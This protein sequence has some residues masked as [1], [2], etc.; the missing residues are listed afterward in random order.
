M[1]DGRIDWGAPVELVD[2]SLGEQTKLPP[3][4]I[5]TGQQLILRLGIDDPDACGWDFATTIA[6]V[7]QLPGGNLEVHYQICFGDSWLPG[8]VW[9]HPSGYALNATGEVLGYFVGEQGL[10]NELELLSRESIDT[11]A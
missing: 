3:Q 11:L 5:E 4:S 6:A 10:E 1:S 2:F 7:N 9:L 8:R